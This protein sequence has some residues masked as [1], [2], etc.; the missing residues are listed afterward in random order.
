[1]SDLKI[2]G[3]PRTPGLAIA[4]HEGIE[5]MKSV[6]PSGPFT[7]V[8]NG[9]RF[10]T[11]V[12]N[13]VLLSPAIHS[14]LLHD[15]SVDS[16][17]MTDEC[18][19][20]EH[21]TALSALLSGG[22]IPLSMADRKPLLSICRYLQNHRA[23]MIVFGGLIGMCSPRA[24]DILGYEGSVLP[25]DPGKVCFCSDSDLSLLSV[26]SLFELFSSESLII[27]TEDWL[28][29]FILS[30]GESGHSLLGC[31][32]YEFLSVKWISEFC[33]RIDCSQITP[34]IWAGLSQR[35]KS[36]GNPSLSSDRC[37]RRRGFLYSQIVSELPSPLST[38]SKNEMVLLYVG[39]RD[40]LDG[41]SFHRCCDGKGRTITIVESDQGYIFGGYTPL[42]W[43]GTGQYK[44]DTSL[45]SFIFTVRNPSNTAPRRFA[46]KSNRAQY[47]IYCSPSYGPTF[48]AGQDFYVTFPGNGS[49]SVSTNLGSSY[50]NDTGHPGNSFLA[51]NSSFLIKKL[52]VF[53]VSE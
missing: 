44:A 23:E 27:Q 52:E 24:L 7:F 12:M 30:L 39:S 25:I 9:S 45:Q 48:G 3:K 21:L 38:F 6:I 31:V 17:V 22:S 35:L 34:S 50:N 5:R 14:Q 4:L 28:L 37:C 42:A 53:E 32:R 49:A 46:L 41:A 16:F 2:P 33:A 1:M 8:V 20:V 18:V 43:D 19:T 26:E 10:E 13:A 29:N 15:Q 11:D 51:G 47:A 40:G 36:V